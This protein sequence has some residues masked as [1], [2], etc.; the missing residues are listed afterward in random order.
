MLPRSIDLRWPRAFTALAVGLV[1]AASSAALVGWLIA[2]ALRLTADR[3]LSPALLEWAVALPVALTSV[4]AAAWT[5]RSGAISRGRGMLGAFGLAAVASA[6]LALFV[7][8]ALLGELEPRLALVGTVAGSIFAAPFGVLLGVVSR[9]VLARLDRVRRNPSYVGRARIVVEAAAWCTGI[10]LVLALVS[11]GATASVLAWACASVGLVAMVVA[12]L[13]H[14]HRIRWLGRVAARRVE[15]WAIF[16]FEAVD[17]P[18]GI[19]RWTA[20]P[21]PKGQRPGVL[22]RLAAG[23]PLAELRI[24]AAL[25]S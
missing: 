10:G 3:I 20:I 25:L 16:P 6:G 4:L 17:V 2:P 12:G 7:V 13:V 22:C 11:A 1:G 21:D 14:M 19:A 23:G 15:G 9:P 18:N 24:P 8:G 5:I